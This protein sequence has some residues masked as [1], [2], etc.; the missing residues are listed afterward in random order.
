M[1]LHA[2]VGEHVAVREHAVVAEH[3]AWGSPQGA[4]GL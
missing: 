4:S 3:V 1:S 2:A